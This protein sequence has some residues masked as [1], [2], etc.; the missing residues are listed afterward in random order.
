[1]ATAL[2][3][4]ELTI[5]PTAALSVSLMDG[6]LQVEITLQMMSHHLTSHPQYTKEL[7]EGALNVYQ[8]QKGKAIAGGQILLSV[9]SCN[10]ERNETVHAGKWPHDKSAS[11]RD[12]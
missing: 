8:K 4:A 3:T 7:C 9:P 1:M 2:L 6:R 11:E 5:L 10:H 12:L